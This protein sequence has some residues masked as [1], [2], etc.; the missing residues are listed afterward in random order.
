MIE[1]QWELFEQVK[2]FLDRAEGEAL[3]AIARDAGRH[4]PSLEIGSYCGKSTICIGAACRETNSILFTIDHHTGSEEQQPGEE[5]FDP[6]LF[7]YQTFQVDTLT[8]FRETL[9]Q[10]DLLDAVV[11]LVC[12]SD[13]AARHWDT[14]L[15]M[16]FIDGG[17]AA[18]TVRLDY[19]SWVPH[20]LPGGYLVFHDI[21]HNP[22]E[23]GQAPLDMYRV[24]LSSGRFHE[25]PMV[26]TL[27]ILRR[28]SPA[29]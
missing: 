11:P 25:E 2:G 16:V 27:G 3:H 12:R 14:G 7:N 21:F 22:E 10:A 24:A 1:A 19:E 15:A 6:D 4:G 29:C 26:N 8:T 13:V 20:I 18:E 28:K 9:R 17:H 5:Y 23:G